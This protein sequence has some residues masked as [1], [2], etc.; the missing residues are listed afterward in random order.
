VQRIA[1]LLLMLAVLAGAG[2]AL[3]E[4][5]SEPRDPTQPAPPVVDLWLQGRRHT[6]PRDALVARARLAP[7]QDVR[8]VEIGRD[9]HT[10]HQVVGI[11]T[12]ETPHRHERHD[13]VVVLLRG[14][15]RM[16]LGDDTRPVGEGSVL[17]V[18][19][20]TVHAF[21]NEGPE[22]AFAH[23]IHAPP[24]DGRDRVPAGDPSTAP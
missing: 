9:A 11:R 14:R 13:L 1:P 23:V 18:P 16:L 4:G 20:G 3:P 7:D 6:V 10:S 17:Y 15:G 5:P 22:P 19:R 2:P 21:T 12:G 8:V 24:F